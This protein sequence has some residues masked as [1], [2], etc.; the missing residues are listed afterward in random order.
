MVENRLCGCTSLEKNVLYFCCLYFSH[1]C[2]CFLLFKTKFNELNNLHLGSFFTRVFF[3]MKPALNSRNGIVILSHNLDLL[4]K[5]KSITQ[6]LLPIIVRSVSF[7]VIWHSS[8]L[9][10]AK[11]VML[12]YSV[13]IDSTICLAALSS[14]V[15]FIITGY[16]YIYIFF[17]FFFFCNCALDEKY[18]FKIQLG[19]INSSFFNHWEIVSVI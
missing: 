8:H 9:K 14:Y 2:R 5:K 15:H 1:T 7:T 17:F 4:Q 18:F 13:A 11:V 19:M 10:M 12:F 6:M 3:P 16:I